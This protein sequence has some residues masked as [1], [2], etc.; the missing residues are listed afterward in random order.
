MWTTPVMTRMLAT[1]ASSSSTRTMHR[2][3]ITSITP[4]PHNK[5]NKHNS[6]HGSNIE[7]RYINTIPDF[8]LQASVNMASHT[9][10]AHSRN[11]RTCHNTSITRRRC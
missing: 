11:I 7:V 6:T 1:I 4:T 2:L 9:R 8:P 10:L 5:H 3:T